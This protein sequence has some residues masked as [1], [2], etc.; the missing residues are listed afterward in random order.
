MTEASD[1]VRVGPQATADVGQRPGVPAHDVFVSHATKDKPVADAVVSRLEQAGIRCWVA[2]RD[3][4]PGM[5]W[6]EAI[7]QAIESTRLMVVIL[8]GDANTSRHVPREIERAVASDVVVIPFRIDAIE[9]TG[10][11]AYFLASE[12]WLDAM[13]PPLEAHIAQLVEVCR[14]L[15]GRPPEGRGPT[16]PQATTP[17]IA[18]PVAPVTRRRG[19]VLA[20][21]A[22]GTLLLIVLGIVLL[23]APGAYQLTLPEGFLAYTDEAEGFAIGHP[24]SWVAFPYTPE[25]LRRGEETLVPIIDRAWW[26][27]IIEE[28]DAGLGSGRFA[29]VDISRASLDTG[30]VTTGWVRRLSYVAVEPEAA[31]EDV[32]RLWDGVATSFDAEP[33]DLRP[34]PGSKVTYVIPLEPGAGS[35][36]DVEYRVRG[37]ANETWVL[38]F[39]MAEALADSYAEVIDAIAGTFELRR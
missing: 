14:A 4:L 34:G 24:E 13:T 29:M 15:L 6:G 9:P 22:A 32:R 36:I 16:T 37:T 35:T 30:W 7:V 18:P 28:S 21:G 19:R 20:L 8:S 2:P 11:M 17:P 23:A 25:G 12:H 39:T 31:K 27:D 3:I 33:V 5:V 26:V 38:H 10:A 1:R